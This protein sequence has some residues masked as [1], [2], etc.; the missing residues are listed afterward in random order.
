M[1]VHIEAQS[2]MKYLNTID[3]GNNLVL[4]LPEPA[5]ASHD[6]WTIGTN[7]GSGGKR[8]LRIVMRLH[9]ALDI[10]KHGDLRIFTQVGAVECWPQDVKNI[11]QKVCFCIIDVS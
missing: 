5:S 6:A 1:S 8:S 3:G 10:L 4:T 7:S 11:A 2:L 9:M